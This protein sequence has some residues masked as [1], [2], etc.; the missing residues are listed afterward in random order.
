MCVCDAAR[1]FKEVKVV[2]RMYKVE[3]ESLRDLL[4]SMEDNVRVVHIES[5]SSFVSACANRTIQPVMPGVSRSVVARVQD[6]YAHHIH[7]QCASG[8]GTNGFYRQSDGIRNGKR[9]DSIW[10]DPATR[11]R[12]SVRRWAWSRG[13]ALRVATQ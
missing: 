7:R 3:P 10:S 12:T 2:R 1:L 13:R 4:K 9:Y 5:V 8:A 11:R 6:F